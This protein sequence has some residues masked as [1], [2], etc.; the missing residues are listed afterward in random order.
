MAREANAQTPEQRVEQWYTS[1]KV[2][3]MIHWGM[4]TGQT[5][6]DIA[7]YYNIADF[8][9]AVSAGGWSA[10]KWVDEAV[11]IHA[12]YI[13]LCSFHSVMGYIKPWQSSIPGTMGTQRDY[14]GE[15]ISA[16]RA[17]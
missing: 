17:I 12:K 3:L 1:A 4:T 9:A 10:D 7:A 13:T 8:E 6:D 15:L 16:A 5:N 2:G 14:L 11:R